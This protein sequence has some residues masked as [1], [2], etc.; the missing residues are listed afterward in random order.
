MNVTKSSFQ[1][2]DHAI[3][4]SI[5]IRKEGKTNNDFNIDIKPSGLI[6]KKSKEFQ[7]FLDLTISDK[8]ESR[9][10][11][12]EVVGLFKFSGS[13]DDVWSF[14]VINAPAILF[15]YIRSY[16]SALTALSGTDTIVLPTLNLMSLK[17]ELENKIEYIENTI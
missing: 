10:I 9:L 5:F 15:P 11:N 2:V 8:D 7:L 17:N 1:F 4:K 14:L 12:V 6:N 3:K 13:L 16:I